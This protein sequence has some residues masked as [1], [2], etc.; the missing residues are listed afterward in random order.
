MRSAASTG[1]SIESRVSTGSS[2]PGLSDWQGSGVQTGPAS[3]ETADTEGD[4]PGWWGDTGCVSNFLG[5]SGLEWDEG[6]VRQ[7]LGPAAAMAAATFW[8]DAGDDSDLDLSV[9]GLTYES[10]LWYF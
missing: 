4:H 6:S 9:F 3:G 7:V 10:N 1:T 2:L 8:I 5:G